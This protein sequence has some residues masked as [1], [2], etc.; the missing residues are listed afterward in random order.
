MHAAS[1]ASEKRFVFTINVIGSARPAAAAHVDPLHSRCI[2]VL[3]RWPFVVWW[4]G[5]RWEGT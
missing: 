4:P 1:R 2:S 5:E 3:G